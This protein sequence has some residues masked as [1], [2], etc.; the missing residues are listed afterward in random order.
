MFIP[1][2]IIC[3]LAFCEVIEQERFSTTVRKISIWRWSYLNIRY[4]NVCQIC[5]VLSSLQTSVKCRCVSTWTSGEWMDA[6]PKD[7]RRDLF[8]VP[9]TWVSVWTP[10]AFAKHT[11]QS[12]V[13]IEQP[14]G[15]KSRSWEKTWIDDWGQ[16]TQLDHTETLKYLKYLMPD[17]HVVHS[18]LQYTSRAFGT[19]V[20]VDVHGKPTA[21]WLVLSW[22]S[23]LRLRFGGDIHL[24][25]NSFAFRVQQHLKNLNEIF[26]FSGE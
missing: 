12:N 13:G 2:V 21:A 25:S 10:Q 26:K 24:F 4:A 7:L 14:S 9:T 22:L 6:S 16:Q 8:L 11:G 15:R 17:L 18:V 20:C 1:S 23:A 3:I 19:P 5:I